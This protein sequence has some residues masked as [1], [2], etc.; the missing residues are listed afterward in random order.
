MFKADAL[1]NVS[2]LPPLNEATLAAPPVPAQMAMPS[3]G[4]RQMTSVTYMPAM[5]IQPMPG[6]VNTENYTHRD[7]N[8]VQL[9]SEQ[10]VST[11]S[12]DVDTG[13]YLS[14][15]RVLNA[16]SMPPADALCAKESMICAS[17]ASP[18]Q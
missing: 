1:E 4:R 17:R 8:P 13:S 9:V 6:D 12:I 5:P 2:A 7:S 11:F 10:P 14:V 18:P 15:R 3:M 16:V